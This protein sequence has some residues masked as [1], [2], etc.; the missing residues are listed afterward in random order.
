MANLR[1]RVNKPVV[2]KRTA[3]ERRKDAH[4]NSTGKPDA[5]S[6]MIEER[7]QELGW[8]RATLAK[9]LTTLQPSARVPY[10]KSSDERTISA[11]FVTRILQGR[12]SVPMGDVLAW[13]NAL[14]LGSAT[15]I[16]AFA[17]IVALANALRDLRRKLPA[18]NSARRKL[19][20]MLDQT[21]TKH[22]KSFTWS[23]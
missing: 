4:Y 15:R 20:P 17:V 22:A 6:R 23:G 16:H 11:S 2:T 10:E 7:M 8:N 3:T 5:F 18:H 12:R 14:H 9:L 19:E 13:A 21:L 1:D